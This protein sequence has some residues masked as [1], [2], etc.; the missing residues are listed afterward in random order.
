[1]VAPTAPSAAD[2]FPYCLRLR[3]TAATTAIVDPSQ[4]SGAMNSVKSRAP[5]SSTPIATPITRG[6]ARKTATKARLLPPP[7]TSLAVDLRALELARVVDVDRLPLGEDVERRLAGLAVAVA[8]VL[9]AAEGQ[10]NLGADGAGVDV[11][12]PGLE[13]AHGAESTV[14]V[15]RE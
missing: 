1:M 4:I 5:P 8:G 11:R 9:R 2:P 10:V 12:D 15:L 3:A 7:P 6:M 13:I 14:D